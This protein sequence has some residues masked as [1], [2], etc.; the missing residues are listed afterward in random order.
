[1]GPSFF[2]TSVYLPNAICNVRSQ[3]DV[4][5]PSKEAE[6]IWGSVRPKNPLSKALAADIV[7]AKELLFEMHDRKLNFQFHFLDE[8][9]GI[10]LER[11]VA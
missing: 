3:M 7:A 1:M 4:K 9:G 10:V 6:S 8:H 11:W 5:A 2:T